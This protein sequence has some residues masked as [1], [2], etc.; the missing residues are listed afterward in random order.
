MPYTYR[1]E[2]NKYCV[3]NKNTGKKVGCTTGSIKKYLSALHANV[4]DSKTEQ[5][6]ECI[7]TLIK[8]IL[9]ESENVVMRTKIENDKLENVLN[10]NVGMTFD[11]KERQE[12]IFKQGTLGVKS[13]ILKNGTEIKFSTSD[14]FGNNKVNV[15]KKLKNMSDPKTLVYANFLSV[16]PMESEESKESEQSNQESPEATKT[17]KKEKEKVYIKLSQPFDDKSSDK[18]DIL[19]DFMQQMEVK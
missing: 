14:M 11:S 4:P 10:K 7:K 5:L 18:L 2:G 1:K 15:I 13:T 12:I 17:P 8:Q 19:G 9:K 3:Y 6:K 16:V